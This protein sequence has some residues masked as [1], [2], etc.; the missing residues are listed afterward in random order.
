MLAETAPDNA[1]ANKSNK[2]AITEQIKAGI[3]VG[4]VSAIGAEALMAGVVGTI[5]SAVIPL[6]IGGVLGVVAALMTRH[7]QKTHKK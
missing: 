4:G 6:A 5:G 1:E 3:G 2:E 7:L